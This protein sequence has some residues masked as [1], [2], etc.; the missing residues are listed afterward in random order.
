MAKQVTIASGAVFQTLTAAKTHFSNVRE[1]TQPGTRLSEPD[2]SDVLDIYRRYCL[3]TNW[4]AEEVVDVTAE[5]DNQQRSHG[6][7]AT[8]KAFA[9]V[10]ASGETK[11]FSMD[12]ALAAIDV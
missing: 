12:K 9:V 4:P 10:I 6:G 2:R 8:T 1:A 7:Y 3:A 11:V 5:W